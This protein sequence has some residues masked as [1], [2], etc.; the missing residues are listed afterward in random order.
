MDAKSRMLV[1]FLLFVNT[2]V[3][4]ALCSLTYQFMVEVRELGSV[5][6]TKTDL[7]AA[8]TTDNALLFQEEKC[9][10]CHTE[11]RF[12]GMHGTEDGLLGVIK[13]MQKLSDSRIQ[14]SDVSRIHA[15]LALLKCTRCHTTDKLEQLG[16]LGNEM[17][18][19]TLRRMQQKPQSQISPDELANIR[20]AF[21]IIQGF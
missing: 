2:I 9:T 5:L 14:E 15:S 19:S 7:Q 8:R 13:R 16:L 3:V 21:H 12:A 11:R 20:Q 1:I 4:V 10:R 18:L 6:A 17:Q